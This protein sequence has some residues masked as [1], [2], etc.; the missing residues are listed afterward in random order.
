MIGNLTPKVISAVGQDR[1]R[2]NTTTN[3][4]SINWAQ[5]ESGREYFVRTR[6]R[7]NRSWG[8]WTN[9]LDPS[10]VISVYAPL[11]LVSIWSPAVG[12]VLSRTTFKVWVESLQG[13]TEFVF[14]ISDDPSFSTIVDE[15]WANRFWKN[16]WVPSPVGA[17]YC[18]YDY[19]GRPQIQSLNRDTDYYIRVKGTNI[20]QSGNFGPS[21]RIHTGY[22]VSFVDNVPD[23]DTNREV[24]ELLTFQKIPAASTYHL[25]LS[26]TSNFSSNVKEF[27]NLPTNFYLSDVIDYNTTCY[28]RVKIDNDPWGNRVISWTTKAKPETSV[29]FPQTGT[30]QVPPKM[31]FTALPQGSVN[32]EW[33]VDTQFDFL[34]S[35]KIE[36]NSSTPKIQFPGLE[37]NAQYFVRVR[38]VSFQGVVG[39]WSS[40][41]EFFTGETPIS[42]YI[43]NISDGE[44]ERD[45]NGRLKFRSGPSVSVYHLQLSTTPDFS[46]SVIEFNNLPNS[47][48]LMDTLDYNTT[49]Y[50]RVKFDAGSW[51]DSVVSWTTRVKPVTAVSFPFDGKSDV[52]LNMQFN[53]IP[54]G[55]IIYEWEVDTQS[56]FLSG[57]KFEANSD[58]QNI[59]F[60]GLLS[61]GNSYYVRVRGFVESQGITG[62]WSIPVQFST[63]EQPL[64]MNFSEKNEVSL[65]QARQANHG[66]L[67]SITTS[68]SAP[69]PEQTNALKSAV[70]A[71]YPN[72]VEDELFVDLNVDSGKSS[73]LTVFDMR[74]RLVYTSSV[75]NQNKT[76]IDFSVLNRGY[77]TVKLTSGETEHSVKVIKVS[78]NFR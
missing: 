24:N 17:D 52:T 43:T 55:N 30:T 68:D 70:L 21:V 36:V 39:D 22:P 15:Q 29:T 48:Y 40:P 2:F 18:V 51:G 71:V 9:L 6:V 75:S 26:T 13:A 61:S 19:F 8:S 31:Q 72:P 42:S 38:G 11:H 33:E 56:D 12:E 53:A 64:P 62:D 5:L 50:S 60:T 77:Y 65:A 1:L 10:K 4:A 67:K 76:K 78:G 58:H 63:G 74:G 57:N 45:V 69:L 46:E 14:Q 20:N 32:Y 59:Q 25:Q 49:Y 27:N 54:Q 28:S 16:G 7:I 3:T 35:N 44:T 41:V 23:A 73:T 47:V 37:Y 66:S 34:G